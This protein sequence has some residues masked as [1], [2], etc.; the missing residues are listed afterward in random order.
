MGSSWFSSS[1]E[2]A[3]Y[4]MY[5]EGDLH[6]GVCYWWGNAAPLC[7]SKPAYYCTFLQHHLR[8]TLRWK[9]RHLVVQNPIIL[10]DSAR[11]HTAAVVT[12]LLRRWKWEILEH[13]PYSSDE[14][15]R[16]RS[17]R[18][19]ERITTKGPVQHKRWTY[20]CYRAANTKHQQKWTCWW[21]TTPSKHL[22]KDNK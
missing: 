5:C 9:R 18:Q 15:M 20:P 2:S 4:T 8:P 19:S 12:D 6:C 7:T 21:W 16:L 22:A 1:K 13:P 3:S 14:S 11:N 10:H 17:L